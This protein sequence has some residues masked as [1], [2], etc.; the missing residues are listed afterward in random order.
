MNNYN[1]KQI[2][3]WV[4]TWEKASSALNREKI[5]ELRASDYYSKNQMLLNEMLQYAF[6]HRKIRLSSGLIEQ[7]KMFM[8]LR[9]KQIDEI[10]D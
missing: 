9:D 2:E 8:K 1:R 6:E 7:Q 10:Y 5:K 4:E 3:K